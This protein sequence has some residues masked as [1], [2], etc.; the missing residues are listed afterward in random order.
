MQFEDAKKKYEIV[1]DG[2]RNKGSGSYPMFK[3]N[4]CSRGSPIR[5]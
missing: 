4:M 3:M 2:I 5:S 1:F